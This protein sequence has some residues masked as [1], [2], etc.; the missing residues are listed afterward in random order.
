VSEL[1]PVLAFD[2]C[3]VAGSVALAGLHQDTE[4]VTY[5][6]QVELAA[7][8]SAAQ[9][10]P[11][12]AAM[13]GQAQLTLSQLHAIVLVHGPGSFTGVRVAISTAKGLAHASGVPLVAVSRLAVLASLSSL[14]SLSGAGA[15]ACLALLDAGRG[16]LYAGSYRGG[17]RLREWLASPEEVKDAAR[18]G[19]RLVAAEPSV[20]E[21]LGEWQPES[22]GPLDACAAVRA[23]RKRV[24]M[25]DWD[26]LATLD[27]NY[28]RQS[29]A[30]LFARPAVQRA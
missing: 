24:L 3:G 14:T 11:A 22:A 13:L 25:R 10:M 29:D 30:Q 8:T 1:L 9:L 7:K 4:S 19:M 2:T 20:M 23:A 18:S 12:I 6:Q 17:E 16:E 28:L 26:D 21:R 5:L 15:P 27:A